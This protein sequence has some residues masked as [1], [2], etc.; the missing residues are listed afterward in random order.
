MNQFC[1]ISWINFWI[2][3][4][5]R[6][7]QFNFELNHFFCPIQLP[8]DFVNWALDSFMETS[9]SV[10]FVTKLSLRNCVVYWRCLNFRWH[11]WRDWGQ[12]GWARWDPEEPVQLVRIFSLFSHFDSWHYLLNSVQLVRLFVHTLTP[13][14][15]FWNMMADKLQGTEFENKIKDKIDSH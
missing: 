4:S 6:N 8:K 13:G 15:Y 1:P 14:F 9:K 11:I 12:A 2:E 10:T 7:F 3:Y 5:R